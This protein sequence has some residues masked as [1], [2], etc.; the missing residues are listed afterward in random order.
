MDP[1]H[2]VKIGY[3]QRILLIINTICNHLIY[4]W[5]LYMFNIFAFIKAQLFLVYIYT[6]IAAKAHKG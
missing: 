5:L 4:V 2:A 6:Y 3:F 1:I